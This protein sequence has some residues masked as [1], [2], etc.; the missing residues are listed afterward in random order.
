MEIVVQK[1]GGSSVATVDKIKAVA[2]KIIKKYNENKKVV[3][4]LSAMGDSTNNLI[5]LASQISKEPNSREMDV[6]LS[7]GEQVTISLLAITFFY[8]GHG[9]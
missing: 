6:L 7:T 2:D 9:K 1:Y 3:V 4:V 8:Q 5:D